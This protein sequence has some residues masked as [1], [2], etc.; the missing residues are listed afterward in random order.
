MSYIPHEAEKQLFVTTTPLANGVTYD[1]TV[2]NYDGYTQVQTEVTASHDGSLQID[3]STDSGGTDIIRTLTIPYLTVNGYQLFGSVC[4]GSYVRYQFTNNSGSL[5]TDFYLTTKAMTTALSPQALDLDAFVSTAMVSTLHRSV[6]LGQDGDG[7][8]SNVSVVET[9]ND[10]GTYH[11]LQVVNG[12]RPSQLYGRTSVSIVVDEVSTSSLAHTVTA[13]KTFYVTDINLTIDNSASTSGT[14]KLEDGIIAAQPVVTCYVVA[15]PP[16]S[17]STNT[18]I[19][20]SFIEPLQFG[21]GVWINEA[22]GALIICGIIN[23]Y[24][25]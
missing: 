14:L 18:V 22:A 21:T 7:S 24:E 20:H 15:D 11:S 13:G 10:L 25:E 6:L 16:G 23:G 17:A 19:S 1:S 8:I 9:S 5:Q 2:L 3:F 12:A 4:F